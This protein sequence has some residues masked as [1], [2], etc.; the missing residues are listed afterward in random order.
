[1]RLSAAEARRGAEVQPETAAIMRFWRAHPEIEL[2]VSFH[3]SVNG[4][5]QPEVDMTDRD[6]Q[7]YERFQRIYTQHTRGRRIRVTS[8]VR[9]TSMEW[10]HLA[11][12][13]I[14]FTIEIAPRGAYRDVARRGEEERLRVE[15]LGE[16]TVR[17]KRSGY[18]RRREDR[19]EKE[20]QEQVELHSA[21]L[22]EMARQLPIRGSGRPRADY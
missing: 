5:L 3:T 4:F 22:L 20:L 13:A 12:G 2:A 6:R 19:L 17:P 9:G 10:F 11:R 16:V 21:T 14:A 7:L 15:G 1:V 8:D 18:G